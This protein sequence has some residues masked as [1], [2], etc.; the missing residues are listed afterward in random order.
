MHSQAD[1]EGRP[2]KRSEINAILREGHA[3]MRS[4]GQV[5]PPFAHLAPNEVRARATA[6]RA[7]VERGLGWDV[8]DFGS[9][10][11]VRTGLLLFTARNGRAA[12]LSRGRGQVYAEKI[13]VSRRGQVTPMHR[14][15]SKAEDIVNRGGGRL[16]VQLFAAA[17]DGSVD[18]SLPVA[19][20]TDG[21]RRALKGGDVLT[22]SPGESVTLLPREHWHAFWGENGDVLIGEVSTVN[23]DSCD[24]VF[25]DGNRRFAAVEED[26]APLHLLVSDYT[27]WLR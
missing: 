22:L 26:E 23:D 13:M 27:T 11:F 20:E 19:V 5:L 6:F 18:E 12:D 3:F 1:D 15:E 8:T 25:R 2:M 16:A 4:L 10:D 24:N 14:H 9:G 7:L 21:V 17:P